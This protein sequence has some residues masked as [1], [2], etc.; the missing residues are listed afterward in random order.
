M[1]AQLIGTLLALSI[2]AGDDAPSKETLAA[3]VSGLAGDQDAA[4]AKQLAAAW[5]AAR[6][7]VVSAL[8]GHAT[9]TVRTWC[10]RIL[11]EHAGAIESRALGQA[12]ERDS[13]PRVRVVA[14]KELARHGGP[15]YLATLANVLEWERD[16]ANQTTLLGL[17]ERSGEVTLVGPLLAAIEARFDEHQDKSAFGVLRRITRAGLPDELAPWRSWWEVHQ[18][19]ADEEPPDDGEEDAGED[20]G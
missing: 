8:Q 11:G 20:G 14:L 13:A 18:A 9:P 5:P 17:I 19:R 4:C 16:R 12:A 2:A 1:H 10:A 6:P 15:A 7:V 3:W